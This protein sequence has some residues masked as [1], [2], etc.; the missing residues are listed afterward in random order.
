MCHPWVYPCCVDGTSN[1]VPLDHVG[2]RAATSF[3]LLKVEI[4]QL[5][6]A[7]N[8]CKAVL[9]C[10]TAG[11]FSAQGEAFCL[12]E[13]R[14]RGTPKSHPLGG[15]SK[16]LSWTTVGEILPPL[17]PDTQPALSSRTTASVAQ[18]LQFMVTFMT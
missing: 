4:V 11:L 12:A 3:W 1:H 6:V 15:F 16:G 7:T 5:D 9:Y 14:K 10:I 8:I 18:G 17:C 2:L 13:Y